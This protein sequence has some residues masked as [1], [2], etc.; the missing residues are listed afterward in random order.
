MQM[1]LFIVHVNVLPLAL[2]SKPSFATLQSYIARPYGIPSNPAR[3][4]L[5]IVYQTV[6]P[7]IAERIRF[8]VPSL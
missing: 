3:R 4:A 2:N 6:V 1:I 5:F 8:T 7:Y